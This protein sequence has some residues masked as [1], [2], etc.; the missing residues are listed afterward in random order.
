MVKRAK[1]KKPSAKV[2]PK[3]A[4]RSDKN[5]GTVHFARTGGVAGIRLVVSLDSKTL[6]P[7]H[8]KTITQLFKNPIRLARQ[9][10]PGS[11]AVDCFSYRM[12]LEHKKR[13]Q[14]L[15]ISE[16]NCSPK[17]QLLLAWLTDAARH[18]V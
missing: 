18:K 6:P 3:S 12:T 11:P 5:S 1:R 16:A 15:V 7:Q 14:T 2:G 10:S 4:S 9:P 17:I 8:Q 13:Q